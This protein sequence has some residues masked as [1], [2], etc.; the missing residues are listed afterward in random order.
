MAFL[1]NEIIQSRIWMNPN[2]PAP[3][4]QD[5]KNTFPITVFDA[6][7][8]DMA[9]EN[10]PTLTDVL[11]QIKT[12]L[13]ERQPILPARPA[14][15]LVT[16]GGVAGAVGSIQ[17]S[18][19]I[20]YDEA[21]QSD[22]KIPTEKAVG[23]LLRTFGYVTE[24]GKP[25]GDTGYKVTWD[26]IIG[27]PTI[28]QDLGD[29]EN[30]LISQ[31]GLKSIVNEIKEQIKNLQD[32]TAGSG[33]ETSLAF[34]IADTNNP[35][36]VTAEQVGAPTKEEFQSH[37]DDTNNPHQVTKAQIGLGNVDNT[38]DMDKPVSTAVQTLVDE[39]NQKI[40]ALQQAIASGEGSSDE[41]TQNPITGMTY[42]QKT[43][44]LEVSFLDGTSIGVTI[45]IDG[46]LNE[47]KFDESTNSLVFTELGGKVIDVPLTSFLVENQISNSGDVAISKDKDG[48]IIAI[49]KDEVVDTNHI[50]EKAITED[51][52]DDEAI[53]TAHIQDGA[54]TGPKIKDR[55]ITAKKIAEKVINEEHLANSAVTNAKIADQAVTGSKIA[56][57]AVTEDKI[58]DKAIGTEKL[59]D[60]AV[61]TEKLADKSVTA[62][63]I[64]D[65]LML[66]GIPT[67][68][69]DVSETA[70]DNR[71]VT[72]K[73][74]RAMIDVSKGDINIILGK[75]QVTG[76]NLFS[77]PIKNRI[78]AVL[79][80]N[81]DPEW[82]QVNTEM[83]QDGA[84]SEEKIQEKS[85]GNKNLKDASIDERVIANDSINN[86][87]LKESS[88]TSEKIFTSDIGNRIL[89]VLTPGS[90]PVYSQVTEDMIA[91]NSIGNQHMKDG[92]I[93]AAKLSSANVG[94]VVLAVTLAGKP[95][96]WT[97]VNTNMLEDRSITNEKLFTTDQW[98]QVLAVVEGSSNPRYTKVTGDFIEDHSLKE[99]N[100][101]DET[102]SNRVIQKEA[103]TGEKIA[104]KSITKEH[105]SDDIV[106]GNDTTLLPSNTPNRVFATGKNPEEGTAWMQ[107]N[108]EMIEDEAVT[109]RKIFRATNPYRVLAAEAEGQPVSYIL[110]TGQYVRDHTLGSDTLAPDLYFYGTPSIETHPKLESNDNTIAD[111][112]WVR[113]IVEKA[114]EGYLTGENGVLDV[115]SIP[116]Q[117]ITGD[118]LF[119]TEDAP[120]VLGID[121]PNGE[122]KYMKVI[123]EMIQNA[124]VTSNKLAHDLKLFGAPTLDIRPEPQASDENNTGNKLVDAQW[125][126]DRVEEGKEA[127]IEHFNNT[128]CCLKEPDLNLVTKEGARFTGIESERV[129]ELVDGATPVPTD[130]YLIWNCPVKAIEAG[131]I[132][133]IVE[134]NIIP[135]EADPIVINDSRMMPI[136][137]RRIKEIVDGIFDPPEPGP[138]FVVTPDD[139][140]NNFGGKPCGG[141]STSCNGDCAT[142]NVAYCDIA[143]DR[144][145]IV[146]IASRVV[147]LLAANQA[148][149]VG[150]EIAYVNGHEIRPIQASDLKAMVEGHMVVT[151]GAGSI[152]VNGKT[153]EPIPTERIREIIKGAAANM[154]RPLDIT[155]YREDEP[156]EPVDTGIH[157]EPGSVITEYIQDRAVTGQKLFTSPIGNMVLAVIEPNSD[158][159]YTK[160]T[161]DMLVDD[162]ISVD[163]IISSEEDYV[164]MGVIKAGEDPVYTKIFNEMMLDSIVN[165]RVLADNSVTSAKIINGAITAPK[166]AMEPMIYNIHLHDDIVATRNLQDGAVENVKI[167]DHTIEGYKLHKETEIPAYTTIGEHADYERRAIRNTIISPNAPVGG[168]NGDIWLR[169]Y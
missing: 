21:S 46:L 24:D 146:P 97:K 117:S 133:D 61:S 67:I 106:L 13:E 7:R 41:V 30:G 35:H 93:D 83:I 134:G 39:I 156:E 57:N 160:I 144:E 23:E 138:G 157:L 136:P 19:K 22:T 44:R 95:A 79:S 110:L 88:V 9:D 20:P 64:V 96:Q 36:E 63:K 47:A 135:L 16:Y 147:A 143:L 139:I 124:A 71:I 49:I 58:R 114:L 116:Y 52:I 54:V 50:K 89:A 48:N 166:L 119:T 149:P 140:Q 158:P 77:S 148:I 105:L 62:E 15:F 98:H 25:T 108:E 99:E 103:V 132:A 68:E 2:E 126:R 127:V 84:I 167:Q 113:Q 128:L 162:F 27:A 82:S 4:S 100:F 161:K 73:W 152:E 85:I 14:N 53:K 107:V 122:A 3:P 11:N 123:E 131:R 92:T 17:I 34:H 29:D 32:N 150:N 109:A 125:V 111:T 56:N 104:P 8:Q 78:L 169:F 66:R 74:V 86:N 80:A 6:V 59:A 51:K 159:V 151:E 121:T 18:E 115:D 155:E 65:S 37:L 38:S 55:V 154:S 72:A 90:H 101:G 33:I 163:M 81:G 165:T 112:Y 87:A 168:R 120:A 164:V 69:S 75:R 129:M 70:T 153:F 76:E 141:C 43:G 26:K 12:E 94:Q 40:T 1:G 5:Y 31:S 10:S 118:K 142:C 60:K 91:P 42:T 45:P 130:D 28:Y 137:D 145:Y 102:V